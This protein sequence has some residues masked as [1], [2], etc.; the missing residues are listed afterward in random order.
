MTAKTQKLCC[1]ADLDTVIENMLD[2]MRESAP[3]CIS[4]YEKNIEK[5]IEDYTKIIAQQLL[6]A[7][8]ADV[9]P[10]V[11]S[12]AEKLLDSICESNTAYY[13]TGV[14]TGA[15]LLMQLLDL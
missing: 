14:K 11:E 5:E 15:L 13:K 1:T 7:H 2:S 4:E 9:M 8:D 12:H 10:A 6:P 3:L